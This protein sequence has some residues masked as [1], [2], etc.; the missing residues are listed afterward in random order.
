MSP[1]N[2]FA[3]ISAKISSFIEKHGNMLLSFKSR[4]LVWQL[5]RMKPDRKTNQE[6]KKKKEIYINHMYSDIPLTTSGVLWPR[7]VLKGVRNRPV[8]TFWN[9][10]SIWLCDIKIKGRGRGHFKGTI[11]QINGTPPSRLTLIM[12]Y[13]PFPH[14]YPITKNQ[15]F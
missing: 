10:R 2:V 14:P 12:Q 11:L 9:L 15:V 5:N 3:K 8:K 13:L 6:Q 1:T 4:E 7:G